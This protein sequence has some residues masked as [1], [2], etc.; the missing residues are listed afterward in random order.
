M[1]VIAAAAAMAQIDVAQYA[2]RR[3]Q[4]LV[5]TVTAGMP[6]HEAAAWRRDRELL[7]L[8]RREVAALERSALAAERANSER[9]TCVAPFALGVILG[10]AAS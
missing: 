7:L 4:Q 3:E 9:G 2:A 8:R 10:V 6:P 1:F 5:A